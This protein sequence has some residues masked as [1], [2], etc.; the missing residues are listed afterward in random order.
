M[1][2]ETQGLGVRLDEVDVGQAHRVDSLARDREHSRR[3]VHGDDSSRLSDGARRSQRRVAAASCDIEH[4][5][6]RTYTRQLD[7]PI[8]DRLRGALER[9]PPS[10]PTLRAVVPRGLLL[11]LY[12][13]ILI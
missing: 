5:I 6:A 4:P 3:H 11:A 2:V 9:R 10:L 13:Q 7:Q 8:V 12:F 1:R